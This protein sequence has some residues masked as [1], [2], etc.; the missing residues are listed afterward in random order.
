MLHSPLA[1][2]S[3]IRSN[4]GPSF[5]AP[6]S[7]TSWIRR[8]LNVCVISCRCQ[9]WNRDSH[10][11]SRARRI[12]GLLKAG[13]VIE[14]RESTVSPRA[15]FL[16]FSAEDSR[17]RESRDVV[18]AREHAKVYTP[19]AARR[20]E[21]A[22]VIHTRRRPVF[23]RSPLGEIKRGGKGPG[24]RTKYIRNIDPRQE[25]ESSPRKL[26]AACSALDRLSQRPSSPRG[27][28]AAAAAN[29]RVSY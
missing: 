21:D 23:H 9:P 15:V 25:S 29:N 5:L 10:R 27:I 2:R 13:N 7:S 28:Q 14:S 19:R 6:S 26:R 4:S 8:A 17:W 12:F 16:Q 18:S 1:L 11:D 22:S 3:P 24:P 20:G